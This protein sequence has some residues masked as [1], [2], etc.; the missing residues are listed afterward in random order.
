MA[1]REKN[2][3]YRRTS[4]SPRPGMY[5]DGSAA[6]QLY[7]D[8]PYTPRRKK[9]KNASYTPAVKANKPLSEQAQR[10]REKA[11]GIGIG[12]IVFLALA[13]TLILLCSI[14]YL[15]LQTEITGRKKIVT[16]LES[17]LNQLKEEND[18]YYSQVTSS[19]DLNEIK[20]K[21]IGS[22]GMKLPSEDQIMT[23]ETEGR[24]YVRQ[25]QDVPDAK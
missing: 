14:H 9:K 17:E 20:K 5:V 2:T 15:Q 21:A 13:C 6:R 16:S 8:T 1:S 22:L 24:S 10:N 25:F 11:F 7:D 4:S 12:Y 3:S 23:Y 19:V 18:A